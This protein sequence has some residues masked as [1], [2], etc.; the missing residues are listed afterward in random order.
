M[1]QLS[2][3]LLLPDV[4]ADVVRETEHSMWT[5]ADD[6]LKRRLI[7]PLIKWGLLDAKFRS[8]EASFF[9]PVES[10]R[11]TPLYREFL[12]FQFD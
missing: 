6:L 9:N 10:I 1:E 7:F 12:R 3:E 11:I 2:E 4:L 5:D 8:G